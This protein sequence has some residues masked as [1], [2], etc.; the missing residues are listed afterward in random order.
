MAG[1]AFPPV[2]LEPKEAA[3]LTL[4]RPQ[5]FWALTGARALADTGEP[6][7]VAVRFPGARS[8]TLVR[9]VAIGGEEQLRELIPCYFWEQTSEP[10]LRRWRDHEDVS[11][12]V[13]NWS[14]EVLTIQ[15][16]LEVFP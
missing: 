8:G 11:I 14:H 12:R 1:L 7:R 5:D 3:K 15:S 10:F 16:H 6:L 4:R 2:T 13:E 9:S